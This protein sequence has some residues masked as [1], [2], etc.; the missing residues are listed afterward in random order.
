M[1]HMPIEKI[2]TLKAQLA[3]ASFLSSELLYIPTIAIFILLALTFALVAYIIL[4]RIAFNANQ[5]L[6]K[7][8]FEIW[9]SLILGYLSGEVSAEEIDKAVE[10]R[11]FNLFA[12]FMEKYL[13]TLKGEDFQN[14][15]L[16]LKKIDLFDYNL[17]RL[18]SKK[19]WDK[20]YA[21]FFL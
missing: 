17:K 19:M 18:N 2:L 16:L 15:T 14:L 20:I 9:E 10:T 13:K 8:Q 21:A 6:R 4:L 3:P 11:Y 7:G 1:P 12:E 5:K